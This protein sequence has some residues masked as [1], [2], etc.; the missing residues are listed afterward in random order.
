MAP[1]LSSTAKKTHPSNS[2]ARALQM[3]N[4]I[5]RK[6]LKLA[7]LPLSL[8]LKFQILKQNAMKCRMNES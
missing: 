2:Q 5:K 1:I 6:S 8:S 4:K 3:K 7:L